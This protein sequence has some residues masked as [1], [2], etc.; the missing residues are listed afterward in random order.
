M[1]MKWLAWM[2]VATVDMAIAGHF[3][4]RALKKYS[5]VRTSLRT[6][7]RTPMAMMAVK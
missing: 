4:E 1:P 2:L 7:A 5:S 3:R 6:R